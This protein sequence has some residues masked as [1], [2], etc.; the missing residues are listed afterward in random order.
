MPGIISLFIR[1]INHDNHTPFF[2]LLCIL[3]AA[4]IFLCS[5]RRHPGFSENLGSL[6]G[7]RRGNNPRQI[8]VRDGAPYE[9]RQN[10]GKF[11]H[12]PLKMRVM[13]RMASIY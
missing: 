4:L 10:R 8:L 1:R 5:Y 3:P 11:P 12:N 9:I 2:R 13:N 6:R 7:Q